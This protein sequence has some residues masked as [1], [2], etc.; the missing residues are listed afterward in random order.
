MKSIAQSQIKQAL[1]TLAAVALC[2]CQVRSP[3][4]LASGF[5]PAEVN[6]VSVLQ[7]VD[8]RDK[9]ATKRSLNDLVVEKAKLFLGE[10]GYNSSSTGGSL[11]ESAV[12]SQL[13]KPTPAWIA[14]LPTNERWPLLLVL[15]HSKSEVGLLSSEGNAEVD[16]ILFD[17]KKLIVA[18][19]EQGIAK[20]PEA[21][22]LGGF[23]VTLITGVVDMA[24]VGKKEKDAVNYATQDAMSTLPRVPGTK[25]K[26]LINR[27]TMKEPPQ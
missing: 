27:M 3:Y 24:L 13:D 23:G 12:R 15:K 11:S 17:K 10:K 4:Y 21:S 5:S 14:S 22:A 19:R 2:S 1:P 16:A 25:P 8:L 18:W 9:A 6:Q 26:L 20:A 7:P